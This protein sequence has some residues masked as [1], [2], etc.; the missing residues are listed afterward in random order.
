[1]FYEC[2]YDMQSHS[3]CSYCLQPYPKIWLQTRGAVQKG[4]L[5]F[6]SANCAEDYESREQRENNLDIL[7]ISKQLESVAV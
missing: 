5:T 1:M 6:C 4:S 3:V 7:Q 2:V